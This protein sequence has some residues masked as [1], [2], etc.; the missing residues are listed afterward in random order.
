VASGTDPRGSEIL[1]IKT[2]TVQRYS[3]S[4]GLLGGG[5]SL[6]D[7]GSG[8]A[9]GPRL[10]P[11]RPR[12]PLAGQ[13]GPDFFGLRAPFG[14]ATATSGHLT[15][16]AMTVV[17]DG[18]GVHTPPNDGRTLIPDYAQPLDELVPV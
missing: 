1:H 3:R 10:P 6:R 15:D 11:V 4:E 7:G 9:P 2:P 8:V 14:E 12:P 5:G 13:A 16:T 18:S 17:I